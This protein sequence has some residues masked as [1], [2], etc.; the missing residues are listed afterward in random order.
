MSFYIFNAPD[1]KTAEKISVQFYRISFPEPLNFDNSTYRSFDYK[2][3]PFDNSKGVLIEVENTLKQKVHPVSKVI[4]R[5]KGGILSE[6][7]SALL[8]EIWKPEFRNYQNYSGEYPYQSVEDWKESVKAYWSQIV[9][10]FPDEKQRNEVVS[11]ILNQD[12]V[13]IIEIMPNWLPQLSELDK[14]EQ[15]WEVF[16]FNS[17]EK[18]HLESK[19]FPSIS[20][21]SI[22]KIIQQ[23][24]NEGEFFEPENVKERVPEISD[25]FVDEL[26]NQL[27]EG[28]LVF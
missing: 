25:D 10:L 23:T 9:N 20:K 24:E 11:K 8:E 26:T 7:D 4:S 16:N 12:Y 5:T 2:T 3:H 15:K 21:E 14:F 6:E 1:P 19:R 27:E 17:V 18:W 28:S 22:D 13:N